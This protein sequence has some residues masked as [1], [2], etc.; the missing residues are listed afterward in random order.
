LTPLDHRQRAYAGLSG[1][2]LEIGAFNEP[3]VLPPSASVKYFDFMDRKTAMSLFPEVDA[4]KL[5][6]VDYIGDLDSGGLDQLAGSSFDF[7]VINHV[8]EHVAN[9]IGAI[10]GILRI[11]RQGGLLA[12]SVP[13][14]RYTFDR[15]RSETPFDH[16]WS[17]YANRVR[18]S[19]DEHYLDFFRSAAPHVFSEPAVN[20]PHHVARSRARRDHVHVWTSEGF[21][22]FLDEVFARLG[23]RALCL[24]ESMAPENQIEYFALWQMQSRPTG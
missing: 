9:P 23:S 2:G 12:L 18:E 14:K 3:A 7:V 6:E 5:V 8:L 15:G 10:E 11:L 22:S 24:A 20:L 17:D 16:L 4:S 13:D 19:S 1:K 21:R